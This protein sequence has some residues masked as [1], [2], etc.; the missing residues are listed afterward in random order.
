[1][2][3][4]LSAKLLL[5]AGI[6][7]QSTSV[8]AQ[9]SDNK[10]NK[11]NNTSVLATNEKVNASDVKRQNAEAE[12]EAMLERERQREA[13]KKRHLNQLQNLTLIH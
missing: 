9:T 2:N 12:L 3:A 5:I 1:M 7:I 13:L 8:N 4:T 10:N 6:A 11:T